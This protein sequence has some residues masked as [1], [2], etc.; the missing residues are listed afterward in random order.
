LPGDGAAD[1]EVDVRGEAALGFDGG[2][3]LQVIAGEPAQVLDEPVEQRGEV[4]RVPRGT[5]VVIGVV[6]VAAATPWWV[7][8][9]GG[10]PQTPVMLGAAEPA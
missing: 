7:K 3:V 5:C 10:C 1:G 8:I 6:D 4:Q 9:G 2:E